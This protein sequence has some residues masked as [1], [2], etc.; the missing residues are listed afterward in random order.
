MSPT[1]RP[2][3]PTFFAFV[4]N[5]SRKRI[6]CGLPQ[7]RLR[8]GRMTCQVGPVIGSDTAPARQPA[9]S[10][11]IERG[12]PGKGVDLRA[13]SSLAGVDGASGFFS[14]GSGSGL[15]EPGSI[16]SIKCFFCARAELAAAR[17]RTARRQATAGIA[18][19]L[20]K[21]LQE[22]GIKLQ[23]CPSFQNWKNQTLTP[24]D[25]KPLLDKTWK[26]PGIG[27]LVATRHARDW[28]F[29]H[30][31]RQPYVRSRHDPIP[32]RCDAVPGGAKGRQ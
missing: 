31:L 17:K 4:A 3:Q 5:R 18:T 13:N 25:G 16:G 29:Y 30:G 11:P 26:L 8:D 1:K 28:R 6:S 19:I 14:A 24:N 22:N 21:G 10:P 7:L 27:T 23:S 15:S 12:G 32:S 20:R 9:K 2:F